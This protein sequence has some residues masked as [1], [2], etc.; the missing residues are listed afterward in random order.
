MTELQLQE[1]EKRLKQLAWAI[2]S[3]KGHFKLILVRCNNSSLQSFLL[4]RLQE[5][6]QLNIPVLHLH[7]S[8]KSLYNAIHQK[9]NCD[10]PALIIV[11]WE[12]L[13][14]LTQILI[15]ANQRR[16]EFRN[17]FRFPIVLWIDDEIYKQMIQSAPDLESWATTRNFPV[18]Q[19]YLAASMEQKPDN[20][21]S[22]RLH[23]FDLDNS[24]VPDREL[25]AFPPSLSQKYA[26]F[27]RNF[28]EI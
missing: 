19:K 26:V 18:D 15:S 4:Q 27:S 25:S 8:E 20:W 9:L 5:I 28:P 17:S 7:Q 22:D 21:F 23:Y 11:G 24:S 14:D 6:C 3:A 1:N 13:Q 10:S 12:Y 16:E 2:Q